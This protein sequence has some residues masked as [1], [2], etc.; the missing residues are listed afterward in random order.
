MAKKA[1][2]NKK[3]PLLDLDRLQRLRQVEETWEVDFQSVM[4][5][6]INNAGFSLGLVVQQNSGSLVS[7]TSGSRRPVLRELASLLTEAMERPLTGTP[8]RP[9][10]LHLRGASRWKSLLLPLTELRIKVSIRA[11]LPQAR[12]VRQKYLAQ[13]RKTRRAKMIRPTTQQ[14]AVDQLFPTIAWWVTAGEGYIEVGVQE[15]FGFAVRALDCG[16]LVFEEATAETLSEAL[17]ALEHGLA[18]Y[19]EE[20]ELD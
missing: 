19:C 9:Q 11:N 8:R 10:H 16:G 13:L 1:S 3:T 2:G 17:T 6:L 5:P 4:Q 7:Q 20:Q 18:A 12:Q 15:G 14:A